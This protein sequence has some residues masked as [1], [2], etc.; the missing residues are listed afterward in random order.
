MDE[1]EQ[2][3]QVMEQYVKA[4]K[5]GDMPV[6]ADICTQDMLRQFKPFV[7]FS[8]F[9]CRLIFRRWW[10]NSKINDFCIES[11]DSN[12]AIVHYT[13]KF[14]RR[15]NYERAVLLK[16]NGKWKIDGKFI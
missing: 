8:L 6:L 5:Q 3:E 16:Q 14:G 15:R 2:I 12:K 13:V 11:L 9:V 1:S 7:R 4:A 10:K